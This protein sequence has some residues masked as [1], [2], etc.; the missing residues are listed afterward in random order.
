MSWRTLV[1]TKR[2]KVDYKGGYMVIRTLDDDGEKRVHISELG[3][4]IFESTAITLTAYLLNEL[5]NNK[6]KVI[7]CDHQHNPYSEICSL[8][9]SHDQVLTIKEQIAWKQQTKNEVWQRIVQFKIANQAE[10]LKYIGDDKSYNSLI[11][12]AKQVEEGDVT[13][14]EGHAA[15]I[16]FNRFFGEGFVRHSEDHCNSALNYGYAILLSSINREV[17]SNGYLTQLG[18]FHDNQ[19]NNFNLSCDLME[20]FRPVVDRFVYDK[21]FDKFETDEKTSMTFFMKGQVKYKGQKQWL[22]NAITL[23]VRDCLTALTE[24]SPSLVE[25][26]EK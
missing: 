7:F 4:V 12:F 5:A 11:E 18:I 13:N 16:Y 20:I 22:N 25:N 1:I 23:F 2:A 19:F 9:G 6:V 15:K 21:N 14:R 24:N 3:T 10:N 26:I 17:S 8:Y